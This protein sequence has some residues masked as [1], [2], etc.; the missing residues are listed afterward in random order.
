MIDSLL[1]PPLSWLSSVASF[2]LIALRSVVFLPPWINQR[3]RPCVRCFSKIWL[4]EPLRPSRKAGLWDRV[5]HHWLVTDVD[6]TKQAARQRALP[7][8]PE[9][10]APHRRFDQVCAPA[11]HGRKRGEVART[12]TTVLQ[13]HSQ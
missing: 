2:C 3:S 7:S 10:P 5:G 13:A 4:R 8:L 12:R 11:L 6:G 9:L 1:L